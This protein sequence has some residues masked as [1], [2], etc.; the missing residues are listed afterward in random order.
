MEVYTIRGKAKW[1]KILGAPKPAY[2]PS[3]K[4]WTIDLILDAAGVAA[5]KKLGLGKKVRESDDGEPFIKFER[6]SHKK[7]GPEQGAP[8]K[9][10]SVVDEFGE[11]WDQTQLIGNGSVVEVDFTTYESTWNGKKFIKPAILSVKVLT[12]IPY[13]AKEKQES[14]VLNEVWA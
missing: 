5:L 2:N 8:N 3:E 4:E 1:A 9:P 13:E 12:H 7:W 10:I 11:E 6:A 14:V